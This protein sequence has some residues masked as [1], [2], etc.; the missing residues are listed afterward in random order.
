MA[1]GKPNV[2]TFLNNT[3]NFLCRVILQSI[4]KDFKLVE[5]VN[6]ITNEYVNL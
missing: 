5:E 2:F 4:E 1:E 6:Q 3:I